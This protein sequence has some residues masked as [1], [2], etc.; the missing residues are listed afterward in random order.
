M[1]D[2]ALLIES[3]SSKITAVIQR[4]AKLGMGVNA[5]HDL[6]LTNIPQLKLCGLI[7]EVSIG[8]AIISD[9]LKYGFK[10]TIMQY[11]KI[12]REA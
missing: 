3:Q 5:G 2:D 1:E 8:H 6:N 10:D 7:E 11:L 4:A 9:A 12:T